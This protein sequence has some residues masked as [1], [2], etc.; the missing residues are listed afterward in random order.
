MAAACKPDGRLLLLEHGVGSWWMDPTLE[1]SSEAHRMRFGCNL[2]RDMDEILH[3]VLALCLELHAAQTSMPAQADVEVV[4]NR[5]WLF[6]L[7][8]LIEARPKHSQE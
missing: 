5:R 4:S 6:G 7:F 8:S 2:N 1:R 3:K